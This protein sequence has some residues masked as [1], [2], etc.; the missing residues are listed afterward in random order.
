MNPLLAAHR[1]TFN[2]RAELEASALCGCCSC[3]KV[4]PPDDIVAWSGLDMSNF[5]SPDAVNGETALCPLCGNEALIG[6]KAG[7]SLSPDFLSRMN[8]AWFQAT[9]IRKAPPKR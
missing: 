5:D 1:H 8:Q 4:F 3:L 7:Y 6:D 9:I 2:N